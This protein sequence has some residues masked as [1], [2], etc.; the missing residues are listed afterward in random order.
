MPPVYLT[1]GAGTHIDNNIFYYLIKKEETNVPK[2]SLQ[3]I[4]KDEQKILDMR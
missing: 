1:G 4:I 3:Q 2:S